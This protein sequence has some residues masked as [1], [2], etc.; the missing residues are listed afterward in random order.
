[1]IFEIRYTAEQIRLF[2]RKCLEMLYHGNKV[3]SGMLIVAGIGVAQTAI[4]LTSGDGL[5]CANH[6]AAAMMCA[7]LP[8]DISDRPDDDHAPAQQRFSPLSAFTGSTVAHI[9]ARPIIHY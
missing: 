8:F 3:A 9:Y 1:M 7:V 4:M 6:S 2:L 5:S